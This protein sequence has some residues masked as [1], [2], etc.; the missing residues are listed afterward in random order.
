MFRKYFQ[1]KPEQISSLEKKIS[2]RI[3]VAKIDE[4]I[5]LANS[6]VTPISDRSFYLKFTDK[7]LNDLN[8][9]IKKLRGLIKSKPNPELEILIQEK[10]AFIE[11]TLISLSATK[12]KVKSQK[13]IVNSNYQE[14]LTAISEVDEKI[15]QMNK[16]KI[17][18]TLKNAS[19]ALALCLDNIN[20]FS[21]SCGFDHK[22]V[23][24]FHYEH[25]VQSSK[26]IIDLMRKMSE[27]NPNRDFSDVINKAEIASDA[28]NKFRKEYRDGKCDA[29][30]GVGYVTDLK[31][32]INEMVDSLVKLTS[33]NMNSKQNGNLPPPPPRPRR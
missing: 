28:L 9:S 24:L 6:P 21:T 31:N 25:A 17:P 7:I 10:Q 27:K 1:T 13:S 11:K 5:A 12:E 15:H 29:A 3:L 16:N 20:L 30:F 14:V 23:I 33:T 32:T 4:Y 2:S 19:S 18:T 22:D 26:S 8:D